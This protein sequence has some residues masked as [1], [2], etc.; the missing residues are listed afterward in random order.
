MCNA[1]NEIS[2]E[3]SV[4]AALEKHSVDGILCIATA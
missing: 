1:D 2:V 3:K 4:F